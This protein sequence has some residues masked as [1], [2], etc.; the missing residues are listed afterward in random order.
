MKQ[1]DRMRL[2]I[3][4][5]VSLSTITKWDKGE[6]VSEATEKSLRRAMS[7]LGIVKPAEVKDTNKEA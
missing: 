2:S 6:K 3:E 1:R 4:T 7:A 5:S